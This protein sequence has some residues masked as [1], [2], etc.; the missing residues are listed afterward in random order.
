[1]DTS[2]GGLLGSLDK[3]RCSHGDLQVKAELAAV[4]SVVAEK[5]RLLTKY[6]HDYEA[7]RL[8]E[9]IHTGPVPVSKALS[10]ALVE[11][12][13]VHVV[14]DVRPTVR[15]GAAPDLSGLDGEETSTSDDEVADGAD[16]FAYRRPGWS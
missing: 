3:A 7:D 2:Y 12:L 13:E 15:L 16:L 14:D 11:R 4:R 9:R 1:M 5:Q 8:A 10:T 6:Q